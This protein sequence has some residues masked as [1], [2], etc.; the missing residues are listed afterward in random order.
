MPTEHLP[1]HE[2]RLVI[3]PTVL[4]ITK[5]I[6]QRIKGPVGETLVVVCV[7]ETFLTEF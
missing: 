1:G 2:K 4:G 3:N 5:E 6:C 7:K